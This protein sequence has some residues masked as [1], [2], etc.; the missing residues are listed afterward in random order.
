MTNVVRDDIVRIVPSMALSATSAA[1]VVGRTAQALA[2]LPGQLRIPISQ[3]HLPHEWLVREV[4][5]AQGSQPLEIVDRNERL[6]T[7]RGNQYVASLR[8][9]AFGAYA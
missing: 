6:C 2:A 5:S 4:V 8:Q 9:H 1:S 3:S 7:E